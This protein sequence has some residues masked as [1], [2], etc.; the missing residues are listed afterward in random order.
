L[1]VLT[2]AAVVALALLPSFIGDSGGAVLA[3]TKV[4]QPVV[5]SLE[6]PLTS[7]T[8]AAIATT[9][10]TQPP[11]KSDLRTAALAFQKKL[12]ADSGLDV[13]RL[14]IPKI[15]LDVNVL[16]MT[17]DSLLDKG[18]GHWP[19]T[20]LPGLSG[21]FVVSGHRTVH[22]GPFRLLGELVPG[23]T[24]IVTLPYAEVRYEVTRTLIVG[25][26]DVDV[27]Q[28]RG[29]EEI[30]LTTCN[31]IGRSDQVMVV[32]AEAVD[33]RLLQDGL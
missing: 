9:T 3:M 32:Q 21:G 7:T 17:R 24:I 6:A 22:G 12:T 5:A 23:D 20:P 8:S 18:P 1:R 16:E 27:V 25:W 30:H 15:G 26:N 14:A 11:S 19:E 10:T 2:V 29:L 13:C 31:P 28:S 33:F 4:G